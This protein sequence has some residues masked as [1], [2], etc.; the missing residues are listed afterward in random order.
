MASIQE[1]LDELGK[2]KVPKALLAGGTDLL[3]HLRYHE[4]RP[5][6]LIDI[7][8]IQELSGIHRQNGKI[9]IGPLATMTELASSPVIQ[10]NIPVLSKAAASV[11]SQQIRNRATVGGNL[12]HASPCADTVPPL[13]ALDAVLDLQSPKGIRQLPLEKFL[14]EP[15][16]VALDP[17]ELLVGIHIAIP[18][19]KLRTTFYKLGRRKALSIA[20]LNLAVGLEIDEGFITNAILSPG[21]ILPHPRRLRSLEQKLINQ[22]PTLDLFQ[23]IGTEVSELMVKET[24]VRWSTPYKKPVV[25][26]L[27]ARCLQQC[28]EGNQ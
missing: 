5:L 24:G 18:S 3:I 17:D 14:L 22:K 9:W 11:G 1:T 19:S 25:A 4:G 27:V 23:S 21:S 10:E 7:S 26:S 16:R 13:I 15:Y 28:L 12:C 6:R 20:R 8:G 2:V